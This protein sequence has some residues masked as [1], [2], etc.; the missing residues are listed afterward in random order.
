MNITKWW[1]DNHMPYSPERI[2]A[3]YQAL[4]MPGVPGAGWK[5][6]RKSPSVSR[7]KSTGNTWN[8]GFFMSGHMIRNRGG[9]VNARGGEKVL[10]AFLPAAAAVRVLFTFHLH[11]PIIP[12]RRQTWKR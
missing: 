1:L 10:P 12:S 3:I 5:R 11:S 8:G 7:A 4:V 6:S 9:E 2:D